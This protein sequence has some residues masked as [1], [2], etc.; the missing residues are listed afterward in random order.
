MSH[1]FKASLLLSIF[2]GVNKIFALVRQ[3][4]IA[5]Q[6]GFSGEIDA[7]NV[8]N[9]LPDLLFSLFS[10]G[11]LALA[12]IPVF[13]EHLHLHGRESSWK[14]F[15][16]IANILFIAT[17]FFALIFAIFAP[18]I[19]ASKFGVSPGFSSSQQALV[20]ELMRINLIAMVVFS[21]S[22][23]VMATL[24]AHKSFL[25]PAIAPIFYN[26]GLI[27]GAV[28]LAPESGF[29]LGVYGLVYGTVLGA[30]GHLLIQIPG[31]IKRQF[32]YTFKFDIKDPDVR[33]VFRL[34][35]PRIATVFLIQV[36][37][38]SR[39]NLASYLSQGSVTALTYGYFILQVPETLIGT[40][41][42]TALLPTLSELI[43]KKQHQEFA[44][45]IKRAVQV[46]FAATI[47]ISIVIGI[48]LPQLIDIIFDFDPKNSEL[49]VW[50]T[51]AYLFG[52]LG[53]S[54]LEVITRAFYAKQ[55]AFTP[56]KATAVRVVLFLILS[57]SLVGAFGVV[58]LA[59]IDSITIMI[60]VAILGFLLYKIYPKIFSISNTIYR[61]LIGSA[62]SVGVTLV[63]LL[64]PFPPLI[65]LALALLSAGIVYFFFVRQE[66]KILIKL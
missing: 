35:I 60:E 53:Q 22:G 26:I 49:L 3:T 64:A 17:L 18:I 42:A 28:V 34:M 7:F 25:L 29:G 36:T 59:L 20:V 38:L 11:A 16:K 21:V 45:S 33:K 61:V 41:I 31:I 51:R 55:D 5:R 43:T 46:L 15:S 40:A 19:V 4:I 10:G 57:V 2:F 32:S 24:Q 56:L 37:F 9:N 58:G 27:F 54:L 30:I 14:L 63:V 39:D 23:L 66:L 44:D 13:A 50:T 52:L 47:I 8:A 62:I 6:F 12:F 65:A 48:L 1:L